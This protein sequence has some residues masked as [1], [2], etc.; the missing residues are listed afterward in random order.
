M[1]ID[2]GDGADV[3]AVVGADV[4]A[5]CKV[6]GVVF[7]SGELSGELVMAGPDG[8]VGGV[9]G[10]ECGADAVGEL[11]RGECAGE[12]IDV[13]GVGVVVMGEVFGSVDRELAVSSTSSGPDCSW[14]GVRPR[15]WLSSSGS[16]CR[17]SSASSGLVMISQFSIAPRDSCM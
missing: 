15:L 5:D 2:V 1:V 14:L 11:S 3:V 8:V 7:E 10:G 6:S 17:C 9:F 16:V 12:V 13:R 4:L